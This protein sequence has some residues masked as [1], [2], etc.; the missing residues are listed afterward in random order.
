MLGSPE[1]DT[2]LKVWSHQCLI[3]EEELL[4]LTYWLCLAVV[5]CLFCKCTLLVHSRHF[6]QQEPWIL[7]CK[8][9]SQAP[10]VH[11]V[12]P[13]LL[14]DLAFPFVEFCSTFVQEQELAHFSSLLISLWMSAHTSGLNHSSQPSIVW[15]LAAGALWQ[16]HPGINAHGTLIVTD[17]QLDFVP[18]TALWA[19]QF[20]Q[21]SS[22][23]YLSSLHLVSF[24]V[25]TLQDTTLKT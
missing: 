11:R 16:H 23:C 12:N 13:Q 2:D 14:Q 18:S 20:I 19:Q 5:G 24:S 17:L 22:H 15:I 6:A 25:W 8:A 7:F 3:R 4:P 10:I 1:L 9:A 21:L